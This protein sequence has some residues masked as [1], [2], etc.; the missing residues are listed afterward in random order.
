MFIHCSTRMSLWV[1]LGYPKIVWATS[2]H[3]QTMLSPVFDL[4]FH[5]QLRERWSTNGFVSRSRIP[6]NH[7]KPHSRHANNLLKASPGRPRIIYIAFGTLATMY[8]LYIFV[9]WQRIWRFP[10]S[11]GKP[12]LI[13]VSKPYFSI[14]SHRDL[15]IPHCKKPPYDWLMNVDKSYLKIFT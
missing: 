5:P 13:Q 11:W 12:Q 2:K 3:V 8:L 6:S 15:G 10:K 14:G 9:T 4:L 1:K 7:I